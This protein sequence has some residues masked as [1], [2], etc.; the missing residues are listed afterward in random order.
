MRRYLMMCC[1]LL[2]LATTIP[3]GE[4]VKESVEVVL[5]PKRYREDD[6]V[7][8]TDVTST[9]P[10]LEP[11]DTVRVKG[12]VTLD[13][14][15]AATL[16]LYLTQTKFGGS[17]PTDRKQLLEIQKGQTEFDLEITIRHTGVLH[18]T[19][20]DNGGRPIGGVYF[21]TEAQMKPIERWTLSH[22]R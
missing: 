19:M 15:E 11:G 2:S 4:P 5:G 10:R 6:V 14:Q 12:L 1:V 16:S 7:K 21:G 17:T 13:S 20:Y 8:I 9:S 3:A 22:Y 18:L